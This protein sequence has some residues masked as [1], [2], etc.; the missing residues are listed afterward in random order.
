MVNLEEN[1]INKLAESFRECINDGRILG[2]KESLRILDEFLDRKVTMGY[3]EYITRAELQTFL[4]TYI[5]ESEK[6]SLTNNTIESKSLLNEENQILKSEEDKL[7]FFDALVNP[8]SP[9]AYLKQ[10]RLNYLK[11]NSEQEN[12]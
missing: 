1:N 10:A 11:I 12:K 5:N 9:N 6:K 3:L 8:P 7:I 4:E 2:L